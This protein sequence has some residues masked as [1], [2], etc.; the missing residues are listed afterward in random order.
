MKKIL[1]YV[2]L[3]RDIEL[4][5]DDILTV[6]SELEDIDIIVK[7]YFGISETKQYIKHAKF[8]GFTKIEYTEFEDDL[9]GYYS[10]DD[11]GEITKVYIY[12][13]LLNET[14]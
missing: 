10:F 11:D 1:V 14:I 7:D 8:L 3:L 9:E 5:S 12:R 4:T 2:A 13:K 6:Q